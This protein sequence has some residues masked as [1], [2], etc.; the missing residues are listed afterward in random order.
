MQDAI[1]VQGVLLFQIV[2]MSVT[3]WCRHSLIIAKC[4]H[5]A[6]LCRADL[7]HTND[8]LRKS[9]KDWMRWLKTELGFDS[10][11]FDFAKVASETRC[12][13]R[14]PIPWQAR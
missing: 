11:R 7:D 14:Q 6:T 1:S 12:R 3:D 8:Q 10:F 9:L 2:S 13:D 5:V 4:S